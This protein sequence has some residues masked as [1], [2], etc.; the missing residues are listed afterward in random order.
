MYNNGNL[1]KSLN[2]IL[3]QTDAEKEWWEKRRETIR[4]DFLKEL[5]DGEK[6]EA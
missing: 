3:D 2:E 6:A 5:G 4:S 1:R